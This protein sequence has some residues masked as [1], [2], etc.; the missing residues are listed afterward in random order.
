MKIG[1]NHKFPCISISAERKEVSDKKIKEKEKSA[2]S[3]QFTERDFSFFS[4]RS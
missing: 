1:I 3:Y 2:G 4:K